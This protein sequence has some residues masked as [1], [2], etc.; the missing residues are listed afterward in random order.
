MFA[1]FT[2][3]YGLSKTV[4]IPVLLKSSVRKEKS[5]T[6][7]GPFSVM[8]AIIEEPPGPPWC[9]ITVGASFLPAVFMT[10]Q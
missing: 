9:Q 6:V 1:A 2:H 10:N 8:N 7:S 3:E 5:F 4:G